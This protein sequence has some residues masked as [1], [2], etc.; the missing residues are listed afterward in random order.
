MQIH[1]SVLMLGILGK[2]MATHSSTLAWEV[3]W[4][5]EPAGLQSMGFAK[6]RTQPS[7]HTATALDIHISVHMWKEADNPCGLS[8]TDTDYCV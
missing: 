5:E 4:A 2:E 7:E 6:C 8:I 1:S 3:P